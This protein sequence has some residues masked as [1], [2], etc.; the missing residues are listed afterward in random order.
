MVWLQG[1]GG[2]WITND[3]V[4]GEC[5]VTRLIEICTLSEV[6]VC[7]GLEPSQDGK[8]P[9]LMASVICNSTSDISTI[10]MSCTVPHPLPVGTQT[11]TKTVMSYAG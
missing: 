8:V 7:V 1:Y 5:S 6:S 2:T 11:T 9:R 10:P 3:L 4:Y